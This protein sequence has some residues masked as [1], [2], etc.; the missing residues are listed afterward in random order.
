MCGVPHAAA[1]RSAAY[2]LSTACLIATLLLA[3]S[4]NAEN[5]EYPGAPLRAIF[6][7]D[8]TD[9]APDGK[10]RQGGNYDNDG[11]S[12][13]LNNN[14]ITVN[15]TD[16]GEIGYVY[17]AFYRITEATPPGTLPSEIT[18]N[19]ITFLTGTA[20]GLYGASLMISDASE[21]LT[22][23]D[24]HI[25]VENGTINNVVG[26]WVSGKNAEAVAVENTVTISGAAVVRSVTGGIVEF[27]DVDV[28]TAK[29][30]AVENSVIISGAATIDYVSGGYAIVEQTETA[31]LTAK[32]NNVTI[33]GAATIGEVYGGYA[34]VVEAETA[35]L[36][37]NENTVNISGEVTVESDVLGGSA[38]VWTA[39]TADVTVNENT[40]NISGEVEVGSSVGGGYAYVVEAETATVTAKNNTVNLDGEV[41]VEGGVVGGYAYV[42]EAGT[43]DVTVNE[44]TVNLSGGVEVGYN[45]FGGYADVQSADT[46]DATANE[47]TVTLSGEVTVEYDVFG[48]YA[49]VWEADTADATVNKNTVNLS[50]KV[51]VEEGGEGVVGGVAQVM[52]VSGT[53]DVTVNE[54]TV[55][56]SGEV[57]V[58]ARVAGGDAYVW[59]A[60]TAD[61]TVNENTVN[62]DGE[63]TVE[64]SVAGGYAYVVEANTAH[65]TVNENNVTLSGGVTVGVVFG[66]GA[67]VDE[68]TEEAVVNASSN[69]VNISGSTIKNAVYG[70][71]A[72]ANYDH[73]VGKADATAS[74]NSV[75]IGDNTIVGGVFG[76]RALAGGYF[77]KG[78][79]V[80]TASENI[81]TISG[82]TIDGDVYGGNALAVSNDPTSTGDA[83]ATASDNIVNISGGVITHTVICDS[84]FGG[85]ASAVSNSG[86]AAT[87]AT[88]NT[89]NI[90]GEVAFGLRSALFGGWV[91]VQSGDG[92]AFTGNRLNL[93]STIEVAGVTNFEYYNFVLPANLQPGLT[94]TEG[95]YLGT[96]KPSV[97]ES[98]HIRG[99]GTAPAV[100]ES[101]V[102]INLT[103]D[104]NVIDGEV[105]PQ[106]SGQKGA[107]LH[108]DYL[109][110]ISTDEKR[111][112]ATVQSVRASQESKILSEGFLAG[113]IL[114]N[115]T[116]DMIAQRTEQARCGTFFD[117]TFGDSRYNTGS[118]V[119]M[120]GFSLLTGLTRCVNTTNGKMTYGAFFEYGNGNDTGLYVTGARGKSDVYHY[121]G[122]VLGRLNFRNSVYAEGSFR[123]GG[124]DNGFTSNLLDIEGN[125]AS[126]DSSSAYVGTHIGLG[127]MLKLSSRNTLDLYSKYFWTHQNGDR[128][129]LSTNDPVRFDS[130][131]SHRLRLGGR[132]S[133]V[134]N[135]RLSTYLGAAWEHEFNGI[136][137]ATTYGY[138]IDSPSLRGSTGIGELG[139]SVKA[140][141]S[142][143]LAFDFGVQGYV[144]KREGVAG[145]A[146]VR[147]AW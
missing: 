26:A 47:N 99:G 67:Q 37:A 79:A 116:G 2:L 17:G 53:A 10:Y 119:D 102:L 6:T 49:Y 98:V 110:G 106:S 57:E 146:Q 78:D 130:I 45:V 30:A 125:A 13:S 58:G 43:A 42:N 88:G 105:A 115:Q 100:G 20:G 19:R 8:L 145:S 16:V 9:L 7:A 48:G 5:V 137:K 90:S 69:T 35:D 14:V 82:S 94:A 61:V 122:G 113:S 117:I 32:N 71:N 36:T 54:N 120:K 135:R 72:D 123:A 97:V 23:R 77:C 15:N 104:T 68:A 52:Y 56:L 59:K 51:E 109:I 38:F 70:G 138:A 22:V 126:Y 133:Y 96:E 3:A 75:I 92:D 124:M 34:S 4:A 84:V 25:T 66:G 11:W 86:D 83:F 21:V 1:R 141:R 39:G 81:V 132:S 44:N 144:G 74:S 12:N 73:I 131:D 121:G 24:N 143:P 114:L 129:T 65:L 18:G 41:T 31:D 40:V 111:L 140:Q 112:L 93:S 142:L 80:A 107:V 147:W 62:L 128:V 63:V 139:L 136:A 85:Y 50:G 46:A 60:G 108:Y 87:Y 89:V 127:R 27:F 33:S 64:Y 55:N 91:D 76:G 29:A 134:V 28:A 103:H 101:I 95:A 118:H